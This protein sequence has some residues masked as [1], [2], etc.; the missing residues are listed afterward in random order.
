M[1]FGVA[2]PKKKRSILEVNEYFNGERNLSILPPIIYVGTP[3]ATSTLKIVVYT[4]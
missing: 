2:K 3:K 1:L 4:I